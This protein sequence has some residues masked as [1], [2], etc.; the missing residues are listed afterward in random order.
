MKKSDS[1]FGLYSGFDSDYSYY[2]EQLFFYPCDSI[3]P[4]DR[5]FPYFQNNHYSLLFSKSF[6]TSGFT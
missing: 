5:H 4:F 6:F 3:T 2:F 1:D